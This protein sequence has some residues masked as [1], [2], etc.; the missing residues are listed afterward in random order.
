MRICSVS[1]THSLHRQFQTEDCDILFFAGDFSR[2]S[3][4][5]ELLDFLAWLQNQPAAEKV[6]IS[7]NHDRLQWKNRALFDHILKMHSIHYLENELIEIQGIRIWGSPVSIPILTDQTRRFELK[8]TDREALWASIPEGTDILLTHTPP[9]GILDNVH[10]LHCGCQFLRQEL[11]R[12]RP[13]FHLFGHIHES[14]GVVREDGITFVNS[15]QLGDD[16][17]VLK[18]RPHVL[19]FD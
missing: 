15:S 11:N 7:G 19:E 2:F 1:D 5:E 6:M 14:Y 3:T 16:S 8:A 10:G 18:N 17:F 9:K 13:R 12:I 4:E